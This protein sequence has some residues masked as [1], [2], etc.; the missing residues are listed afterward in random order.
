MFKI[1][2]CISIPLAV[3]YNVL[4]KR[5]GRCVGG[6]IGVK[7]AICS[8]LHCGRQVLGHLGAV[9]TFY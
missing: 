4:G 6:E 7:G 3:M 9:D 1:T 5:L 8:S 2:E